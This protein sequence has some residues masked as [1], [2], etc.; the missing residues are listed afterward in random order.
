M[1]AGESRVDSLALVGE[2]GLFFVEHPPQARAHIGRCAVALD[3]PPGRYRDRHD[4]HG[5][6]NAQLEDLAVDDE[7]PLTGFREAIDGYVQKGRS[8]AHLGA[9]AEKSAARTVQHGAKALLRRELHVTELADAEDPEGVRLRCR[10]SGR[11]DQQACDQRKDSNGHLTNPIPRSAD[12]GCTRPWPY[13]SFRPA[14]SGAPSGRAVFLSVFSIA[15]GLD[16]P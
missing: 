13:S 3:A 2:G 5:F 12:R 10:R 8:N 14:P 15:D 6:R 7:N 4:R 11:S 16:T 9:A 1:D